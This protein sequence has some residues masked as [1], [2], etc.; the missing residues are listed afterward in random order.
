[1]MF[2]ETVVISRNKY[3]YFA[4]LHDSTLYFSVGFLAASFLTCLLLSK[5]SKDRLR[6]MTYS[7]D[8]KMTHAQN[9]LATEVKGPGP[10]RKVLAAVVASAMIATSAFP[11]AAADTY[12]FRYKTP[13]SWT[14]GNN[15]GGT[16]NPDDGEYAAGNDITAFYTGAM[17]Q[18]FSK[19]LAVK[20]T[21]VAVW[22]LSSGTIQPGLSLDAATGTMSGIPS[23]LAKNYKATL[24]GYTVTGENVARAKITFAFHVAVGQPKTAVFYGHTGKYM[25]RQ[26]PASVPV[27]RWETLTELPDDFKTTGRYLDGTP[28]VEYDTGVAFVGYDFTD[29]EVAFASGDL[30]VQDTPVIAHIDDQMRHPSKPFSVSPSVKY[31]VGQLTFRLVALDGMPSSLHIVPL[32]GKVF[33]NIPTFN[34]AMRFRIEALDADGTLGT[35]N[36]FTLSTPAPDTD[37]SNM[38][39]QTG[40]VGTA[41]S[42][43][44]G[45]KDLSGD[46]TWKVSSGTLPD[47]I[48]LDPET[49]ELSGTPTKEGVSGNIVIAVNTSDGG[50]AETP[51][52]KFTI[53]PQAVKVAFAP[54]DVRTGKAFTSAGPTLQQGVLPPYKFNPVAGASIDDAL[55]VDYANA[56]V[57]GTLDVAGSYDVP[58][59]FV[60]GNGLEQTITQPITV[61]D[62]LALGYD[63]AITLYRRT[64]ASV[65]PIKQEGVVGKATYKLLDGTLPPGISIDAQLGTI[66]G[67]PTAVN[68]YPDVSV[69]VTDETGE[70]AN[71]N[72]FDIEVK[73]RAAV[74]VSVG[75][76]DVERFVDNQ[77]VAASATNV[78]DGVTYE[79]EEGTLPEGLVL[80]DDGVITG[81]TEDPIGIYDG[82]KIRATDGEGYSTL[83]SS[84]SV[85][86]VQPKDLAPLSDNANNVSA[87]WAVGI[88]FSLPLPRP[89]NAYGDVSYSL[90]GLPAGV[91]VA[92][93]KLEGRINQVG[94]FAYSMTLTDAAGRTLYGTY[95]L[96]IIPLMTAILDGTGKRIAAND[97]DDIT[98]DL[99]RGADSKIAPII[100]NGIAPIAYVFSGT[101]PDGM[102]YEDG[103]V[104]GKAK[105][106]GQTGDVV[107]T[108]IDAVGT[109]LRLS[110][111]MNVLE[112]LP[113]SLSYTIP[114]PAGFAGKPL[115][116][117]APVPV[118]GIGSITYKLTGTLPPGVSF[119]QSTGFFYGTPLKEGW[120][121]DLSVTATDTDIAAPSSAPFGPFKL[122]IS[123]LGNPVLAS[124]TAFTVR[125]GKPFERYLDVTNVVAPLKFGAA[126]L[127]A[128]PYGLSL[129]DADG[130]IAG[131]LPTEGNYAIGTVVVLDSMSR[132]DQTD[133]SILA[134]GPLSVAAPTSA[135]FPQY[136]PVSA[137]AVPTNAVGSTSY[138]LISGTLP[139]G[140]ALNTSTGAITGST[141][142]KGTFPGLVIKVTDITGDS[143]QTAAFSITIG[144]R[145]P[146]TMDFQPTY[147]VI[148]NKAFKLYPPVRNYVGQVTFVQTGDLPRGIWYDTAGN[149]FRGTATVIG[150][151]P[152]ITLTVTD[153]VGASV[154][155][156]FALDIDTNG[157]PIGL[158][159]YDF[160][161]KKGFPIDTKQPTW[162]NTVGDV[163][164]WADDTLAD[165]GLSIDPATGIISGTATDI[166]SFSPNVNVTDDSNRITSKTINIKVVSD[167]AINAPSVINLPVNTLIKP[168]I[169]LTADNATGS[170][171]WELEGTL[172]KGV[173]FGLQNHRFAGTPNEL[174]TFDLTVRLRE[175]T[176][177]LQSASKNIRIV[178]VSNGLSPE[179]S[180]IPQS[181]GYVVTTKATITPKYTNAKLGDVLTLSP[182]S[183]PLPFGMTITKNSAG[184]Y[185]LTKASVTVADAGIYPG[186]K[187]RVT[188]VEGKFSDSDPFTIVY[189][190]I[191]TIPTVTV[192]V[193]ANAPLT[194]PASPIQGKPSGTLSYSMVNDGTGGLLS[195][196]SKTGI[197]TG[198]VSKSGTV[199]LQ[200]VDSYDNGIV[201][202][203][204]NY[205]LS[206]KVP[207]LTLTAP[208]T[209]A[210]YMG[211]A[212]PAY[213]VTITNGTPEGRFLTSG[214]FPPGLSIDP[215]NGKIT[216]TPSVAGT[217]NFD[218]VYSDQ[219]GS[220]SK[221]VTVYIEPAVADGNGYKYIRI[222]ISDNTS[223]AH[224]WKF[225]IHGASGLDMMHVIAPGNGSINAATKNALLSSSHVAEDFPTN[226]YQTFNLPVAVKTGSVTFT[227]HGFGQA[228]IYGSPDG[229]DWTVLGT[230]ALGVDFADYTV[231]FTYVPKAPTVVDFKLSNSLASQTIVQYS[232]TVPT[233]VTTARLSST[234]A[235]YPGLT[236][237][238]VSGTLPGGI[239]AEPNADG[240]AIVYK[241]NASY[242][243]T[244]GNIV[245]RATDANGNS[246]TS[247][248]VT[249]T[250][251]AAAA[252]S[253]TVSPTSGTQT[254]TVGKGSATGTVTAKNIPYGRTTAN[255]DWT[256]T[257]NLPQG[258]TWS[259]V[260][261][262]VKFT[263]TSN[264]SGSFS[265]N[266]QA[267]ERVSG[268]NANAW[269]SVV[270]N[271]PAW[272]MVGNTVDSS[273][274]AN[275]ICIGG[276]TGGDRTETLKIGQP[277]TMQMF[278]NQNSTTLTIKSVSVLAG[279]ALPPGV[280]TLITG[281][282]TVV[283]FAGAPT[284]TGNY[285]VRLVVTDT[286]NTA[287]AVSLMNFVV[288]P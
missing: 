196:D 39:D 36:V 242:A 75:P 134:V 54:V 159:V 226:G 10:L 179:V 161:T 197:V 11:A 251:T 221:A 245:W 72:D 47:G 129:G 4:V 154:T 45:G 14:P 228:V 7:R 174:G 65:L 163:R 41:Y 83:S 277:P 270:M 96:S 95:N 171:V 222:G 89:A 208:A 53:F 268:M 51:N 288:V 108:V 98:F 48:S 62:P 140:L 210:S 150:H 29:K 249:F 203:K 66:V 143:A 229:A 178:V 281:N 259:V 40:V 190:S 227:G 9:T 172:P 132:G 118:N 124:K 113:M 52:F 20:T 34:T 146:L 87:Q 219:Y 15:N 148:A 255:I 216:G 97:P 181:S 112:R 284:K 195:V 73:D 162:S 201:I 21:E 246:A 25:F 55:Y 243:G 214:S 56:V 1:M 164:L 167:L 253:V 273:N 182:D 261:G 120:S 91:S 137:K 92:G 35:S 106:E 213:P 17:G 69:S 186:I 126:T 225:A 24:L 70:T 116:P 204:Q 8:S 248:A 278:M 202:K 144:D 206:V 13:A 43:G 180:V 85:S 136:S 192:T 125:A 215:I 218:I 279:T 267:V 217:Y 123:L 147:A 269:Y 158:S 199:T 238:K 272:W 237:T 71:S 16:D 205:F 138:A 88:D 193:R 77:V 33:G 84:F 241:G 265:A 57:S 81:T 200:I 12:F 280:T 128:L 153:S 78:F 68:I 141:A 212:F 37:I 26:V 232:A 285:T 6:P 22:K 230:K 110:G 42:L 191:L 94:T 239:T 157:N 67:T 50:H 209:M 207:A 27:A 262:V 235:V 283:R 170:V 177:F 287:L 254:L 64:P 111:K 32:N 173:G 46:Q 188:D 63:D 189:R 90:Q 3:Y 166:M 152:G 79:L 5:F 135:S 194:V 2:G 256:V 264:F 151:F 61:H 233:I 101:L 266:I 99:P 103:V 121:G 224:V 211:M 176:G 38:K 187:V 49:G 263:G 145:L 31:T 168:Y 131:M 133:V 149:L 220:T 240:S 183:A 165:H 80:G 28:S 198:V 160:T 236:W 93:D 286:A 127:Q 275:I 59:D 23:G 74:D 19:T 258:I 86:V 114:E 223:Y 231:P 58:F 107:M 175:K 60:N 282:N 109:S 250:V 234:N 76:V 44:I 155:K 271:G 122:G 104:S 115:T 274:S 247:P 105:T 276:C 130:K 119:D 142:V 18:Q 102:S 260:N 82:L 156:T 257:G 185:V 184:T 169:V 117:I 30:I 100:V 252:M 139:E 244:Y